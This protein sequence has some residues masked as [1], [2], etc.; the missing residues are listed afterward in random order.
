MLDNVDSIHRTSHPEGI[1][2]L[3]ELPPPED[4]DVTF[5]HDETYASGVKL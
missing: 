2:R 1:L 5:A 3:I 4:E